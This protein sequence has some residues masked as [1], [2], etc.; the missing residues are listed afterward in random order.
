[1]PRHAVASLIEEQQVSASTEVA[2]Q[3]ADGR[4]GHLHRDLVVVAFADDVQVRLAAISI[5]MQVSSSVSRMVV[6]SRSWRAG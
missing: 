6:S 2:V 4:V 5:V 1:V 3:R